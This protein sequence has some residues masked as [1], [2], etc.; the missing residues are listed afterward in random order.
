MDSCAPWTHSGYWQWGV[1]STG[2]GAHRPQLA[3]VV[4]RLRPAQWA[5]LRVF[6][7]RSGGCQALHSIPPTLTPAEACPQQ[8]LAAGKALCAQWEGQFTAA[9]DL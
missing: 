1:L 9:A 7:T 3:L 6:K 8:A 5:T 2:G 4:A